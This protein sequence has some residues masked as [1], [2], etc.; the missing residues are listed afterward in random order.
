MHLGD[1]A[2]A[3]AENLFCAFGDDCPELGRSAASWGSLEKSCAEMPLELCEVVVYGRMTPSERTS[4]S[5]NRS[6]GV[7]LAQGGQTAQVEGV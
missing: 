2:V 4:C 7:T 5:G 3:E 1:E 6:R